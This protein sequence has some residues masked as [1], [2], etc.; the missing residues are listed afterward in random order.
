MKEGGANDDSQG[1]CPENWKDKVALYC[2]GQDC[3]VLPL[4]A[5]D[6]GFLHPIVKCPKVLLTLRREKKAR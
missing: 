2:D 4:C 6:H 5:L 3:R 1:L